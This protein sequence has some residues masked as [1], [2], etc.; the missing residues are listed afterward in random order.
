MLAGATATAIATTVAG[1]AIGAVTGGLLGALVGL[2]IPEERARVYQDRISR[3]HYLIL[4]EGTDDEISRAEAILR[5]RGIEG[6]G[7]LA[8]S[9][10]CSSPHQCSRYHDSPQCSSSQQA[11][12]WRIFSPS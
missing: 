4:V 6:V 3:G 5:H 11:C 1:G 7:R 10:C 8:S 2:G 9:R 12:R